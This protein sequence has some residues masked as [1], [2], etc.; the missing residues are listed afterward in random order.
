M[1]IERLKRAQAVAGAVVQ[2]SAELQKEFCSAG[3]NE[4]HESRSGFR[5]GGDTA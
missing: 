3:E 4:R 1:T 5:N 2:R